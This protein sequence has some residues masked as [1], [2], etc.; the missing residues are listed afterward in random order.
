M[1]TLWL[2]SDDQS[3]EIL[4]FVF[5]LIT[6]VIMVKQLWVLTSDLAPGIN[7]WTM[8]RISNYKMPALQT[9]KRLESKL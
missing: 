5:L 7:V 6:R 1:H 4:G 3:L 9:E 2:L 8:G